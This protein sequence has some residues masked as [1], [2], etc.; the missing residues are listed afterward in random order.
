VAFIDDS[1]QQ[2][3]NARKHAPGVIRVSFC[4]SPLV[5]AVMPPVPEAD[6]AAADWPG[7]VRYLEHH[8]L[9]RG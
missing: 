4:G 9:S 6:H 3:A 1:P 7:I 5:R 2:I 8:P